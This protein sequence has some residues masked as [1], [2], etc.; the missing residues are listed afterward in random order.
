MK[1]FS[2][3]VSSQLAAY[4][5][6]ALGPEEARRIEMHLASCEQCQQERNLTESGMAMVNHLPSVQA[7]DSIWM[8][9]EAAISEP[10]PKRRQPGWRWQL[11]LAMLAILSAAGAVLWSLYRREAS[12][13]L[14]RTDGTPIV[15]AKPVHG[16]MRI[17]AGE[18]I[19]TDSSSSATVSV[20]EIGSVEI[21]PRTRLLVITARRSQKRLALTR[22]QI[23]AKISAPPKLF[24]VD[25][26]AGTA[27]DLGCE[28]SLHTDERGSGL[29]QV[30]QGWVS[31]QWKGLESLVPAGA[32][33][34]T[35]PQAGPEAPYFDDASATFKQALENFASA[36]FKGAW[37]DVILADAR[38]RDTLTLW[39]LLSRVEFRD[40][41]RIYDRIAALTPVPAGVSRDKVLNL[42]PETLTRWRDELAWTW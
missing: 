31:F 14:V 19:E 27:V 41:E 2:R 37:L 36:R 3:H 33:C 5:D 39:H 30:T 9:I 38:V 10:R 23:H 42:D 16:V 17:G 18:W 11:A 40:R 21:A 8:A 15:D 7:P 29:L 25:T 22:G 35:R 24:L 13:E 12:W 20:G 6:G 4:I 28:Y 34:R 1:M 32:S 26:A